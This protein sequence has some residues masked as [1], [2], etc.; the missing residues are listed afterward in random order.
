[1]KIINSLSIVKLFLCFAFISSFDIYAS[2]Q[3]NEFVKTTINQ[4]KLSFTVVS[5]LDKQANNLKIN[6]HPDETIQ[7]IH[8]ELE[9]QTN[10]PSKFQELIFKEKTLDRYRSLSYYGIQ[11]GST[12]FLRKLGKFGNAINIPCFKFPDF[13][14]DN[15]VEKTFAKKAEKWRLIGK[16]LNLEGICENSKCR[17]YKKKVWV[18][19]GFG[20]FYIQEE[21]CESVCPICGEEV[22]QVE[23]CGF[24]YCKYRIQGRKINKEKIDIEDMHKKKTGFRKFLAGKDNSV[25][26][27][28]LKI[29]V[30][31]HTE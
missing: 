16:G 8:N 18:P 23:Q 26:Y 7:S 4:Q 2:Q 29:S 15:K 6:A 20:V 14:D 19:K 30:T 27:R 25:Q 21:V 3:P 5:M 13:T 28:F 17:A 22:E 10:F 11:T 24:F 9:R 1:M 12:L 31:K